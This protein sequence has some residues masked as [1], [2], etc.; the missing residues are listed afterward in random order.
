[1]NKTATFNVLAGTYDTAFTESLIGHAQRTVSHKW[2]Q[3]LL[4]SEPG[5]QL[6][7]INCGT[8]ADACWMAGQGHSV[9]ATDG[10]PAM[11]DKAQQK[12]AL[13]NGVQQP[14]FQTCSFEELHTTFPN[15]Q[16]DAIV[17]NFAGL[18]CVSPA[19]MKNLSTQLQSL[20]RPGGYLAV[21]LFGKYCFWDSL[22]HLLK[23]QPRQA[24]R[25]FTNKEVLVQLSPGVQQPV[26]Y[27]SV[28]AFER[29]LYPMQ[30]I[31]KKPV[32][33]FIPPSWL[34]GYMQ[35]HPRL[36]HWLV[37]REETLGNSSLLTSLA[38]HVFL[39]FKNE[40]K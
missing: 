31:E 16:F 26:Y 25:R 18:N 38:D 39:L 13:T 15:R 4:T 1:M 30:L 19:E 7:E 32:G 27:Y 6:L 10:S 8:G 28:K 3:P 24:F 2:L 12:T 40:S 34:E 14:A 37:Q 5:M 21:V 22:Y 35:Q 23:G 9:I 20:L 33:L 36:F 11:I 17:S 29:L